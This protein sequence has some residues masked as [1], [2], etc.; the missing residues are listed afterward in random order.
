MVTLEDVVVFMKEDESTLKQE[1]SVLEE[2]ATVLKEEMADVKAVRHRG[3]RNQF[4]NL[5]LCRLRLML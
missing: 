1:V 2:D 5:K 3:M 4:L